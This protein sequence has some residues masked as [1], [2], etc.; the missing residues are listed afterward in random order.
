M[1]RICSLWF[2]VLSFKRK[3][4]LRKV[5]PR[6]ASRLQ[7]CLPSQNGDSNLICIFI[8]LRGIGCIWGFF[9][10]FVNGDYLCNFMNHFLTTK[11]LLKK[12]LQGSKFF[13]FREDPFSEGRKTCLNVTSP[14]P[15]PSHPPPPRPPRNTPLKCIHSP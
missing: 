13:P 3:T 10:H 12:G 4:H 2:Q 9:R 8:H 6:L 14:L 15:L 7:S 1:K 11:P 5:S